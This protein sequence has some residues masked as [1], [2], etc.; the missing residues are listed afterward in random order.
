[1]SGLVRSGRQLANCGVSRDLALIVPEFWVPPKEND[2][3]IFQRGHAAQPAEGL[4]AT[5]SA[6]SAIT[7]ST[8]VARR[9]GT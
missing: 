1:L 7:G 2:I 5:Y 3:S 6:R 8:R 4:S 9:V